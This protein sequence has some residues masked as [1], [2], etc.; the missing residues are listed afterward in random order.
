LSISLCN[1][2]GTS[3]GLGSACSASRDDGAFGEGD[4]VVNIEV[5]DG[6]A[7]NDTILGSSEDDWLYGNGGDDTIDGRGGNDHLDGNA[8]ANVLV[9][10][11]GADVCQ[12]YVRATECDLHVYTCNVGAKRDCDR[13]AENAC[14][15]DVST[16]AAHC[17]ACGNVCSAGLVCV[18]GACQ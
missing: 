15:T 9:G 16:N 11:S 18:A 7:G 14:E 12:N 5:V 13:V 3:F 2:P 17:G 4:A 10:G 1:D 8:G 6:G